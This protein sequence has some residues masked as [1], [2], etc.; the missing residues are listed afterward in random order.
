MG[1]I[2]HLGKSF[3]TKHKKLSMD[4]EGYRYAGCTISDE[5]KSYIAN[6]VLVVKE[7]MEIMFN[8]GLSVP[9][10]LLPKRIKGG[11]VLTETTYEMR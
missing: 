10:K 11:I 2:E 3:G 4:Y 9:G 7:A 6:D 1:E 5:E 8:V